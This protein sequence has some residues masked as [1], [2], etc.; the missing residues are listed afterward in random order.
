M[1][2]RRSTS[3]AAL[4]AFA[5]LGA[6]ACSTTSETAPATTPVASAPAAVATPAAPVAAATPM[7][8]P[9]QF[10]IC[11]ACHGTK[12]GAPPGLGPNL[13]GI[14]GK[15][16]GTVPGYVYSDAMKASTIVWTSETLAAFTKDPAA[17]IP[18]NE[19][20]FPGISDPTA[21]KAI[22]DYMMSLK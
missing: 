16:A 14:A 7:A 11:S 22:A 8:A 4:A 21:A 17:T 13:F 15:K 19:M 18:D 2:I 3:I 6:A 10:A 20:D 12:A 1:T 5:V 9:A